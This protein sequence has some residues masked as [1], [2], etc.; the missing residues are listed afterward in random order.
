MESNASPLHEP[1]QREKQILARIWAGDSNKEIAARLVISPKT[2]KLHVHN[3]IT[4]L[5]ARN[6][7][8]AARVAFERGFID[9][10]T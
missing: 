10:Q 1:T 5:K 3:I 9:P 2:A 8:E 6:R 7:T 4:K